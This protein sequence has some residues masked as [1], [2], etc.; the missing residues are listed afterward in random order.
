[1]LTLAK[2][3]KKGLIYE[4]A[5]KQIILDCIDCNWILCPYTNTRYRLASV[6]VYIKGYVVD[7][8]Y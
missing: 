7:T 8:F 4:N 6:T 3:I 1:M 5:Q 2:V